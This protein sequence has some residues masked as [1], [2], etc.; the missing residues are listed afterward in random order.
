MLINVLTNSSFI[1]LEDRVFI[2]N[3][4]FEQFKLGLIFNELLTQCQDLE[5]NPA[6]NSMDN[7]H[8]KKIRKQLQVYNVTKS[9]DDHEK[10]VNDIDLSNP[11]ALF[12]I[13]K[14]GAI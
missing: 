12:E 10:I 14:K 6:D 7:L 2:R 13:I 8:A 4:Q 5:L 3:Y 11:D 9:M 1:D